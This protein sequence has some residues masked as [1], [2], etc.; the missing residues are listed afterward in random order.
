MV[1]FYVFSLVLGGGFL[2]LSLLGDLFGGHGDVDLSTDVAL[3]TDL[4]FDT[5]MDVQ[6]DAD[7]GHLDLEAASGGAEAVHAGHT[8]LAA[9]TYG[10]A[11]AAKIFSVRTVIYAL[12]GF[13][14]VGTLL[15]WVLPVGSSVTTAAFAVVGGMLSGTVINAAFGWVK[16]SDSG[17]V[18]GDDAFVGQLA[19]VTLPVTEK[20][21]SSSRCWGTRWS[22][23]RCRIPRQRTRA[24]RRRGDPWWWSTCNEVSRSSRLR[25][26][27]CSVR[28]RKRYTRSRAL[29]KR[30]WR[31]P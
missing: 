17:A 30:T 8:D 6:L 16:R 21:R 19:R 14:A 23:A 5:D 27:S 24:I 3:D 29:P 11:V 1:A 25:R 13:G 18:K 26:R 15:T 31:V 20:G 4:S 7:V 12:F 22:Y 2:G 10:S 28:D 9:H